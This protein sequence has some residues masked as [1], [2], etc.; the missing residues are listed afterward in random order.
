MD[1]SKREKARR[2]LLEEI[3]VEARDT[4]SWTGRERFSERVMT[5]M[6]KVPRHEFVLPED[7]DYAYINRP[8]DIGRGQTISQPYIVAVMTD[9]LDLKEDDRILEIGAGSGY[10]AAV[11][12]E[13]AGHVYSVETVEALAESARKRL[14]R[15]GYDNVHIRLGDGYEG[16]P[17]EAPFDAVIV[18]A[19]P[20]HIPQALIEQLKTHGRMVIPVGRVHE[21]QILNVGVKKED[22]SLKTTRTLPVAFVPMVRGPM[23]RGK[24]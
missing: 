22:G 14:S 19:A 17:D 13:I 16:W 18:T 23:V 4:K 21:T 15:L 12:A 5:A 7:V 1:E 8:R 11:L 3:E 10:Q 24:S 2:R 20:E 9:L 6:A